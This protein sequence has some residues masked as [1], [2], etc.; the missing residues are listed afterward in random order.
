MVYV[1]VLTI[2]I[3]PHACRRGFAGALVL[4]LYLLLLVKNTASLDS[5]AGAARRSF[6]NHLI[7]QWRLDVVSAY[8]QVVSS[9]CLRDVSTLTLTKM[10][11]E[12]HHFFVLVD[13]SDV[14]ELLFGR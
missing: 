12:T 7:M 14:A 1:K 3:L 8:D 9:L 5:A 6:G 11:L 13:N 4:R 10:L 2:R